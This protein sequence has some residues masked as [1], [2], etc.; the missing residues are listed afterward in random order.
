ARAA[1]LLSPV[2]R[3][4]PPPGGG[5]GG[6]HRAVP[7]GARPGGSGPPTRDRT[8][9]RGRTGDRP[10]VTTPTPGWD[11]GRTRT[12]T[13]TGRHRGCRSCP[14]RWTLS[15]PLRRKRRGKVSKARHARPDGGAA[16]AGG[17]FRTGTSRVGTTGR[18][19]RPGE[20]VVTTY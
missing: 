20:G 19:C 9:R 10:T 6:V 18:T 7:P 3:D 15:S 8:R 14:G 2:R 16:P 13:P 12:S 5:G 1:A 11:R 17:A 4:V